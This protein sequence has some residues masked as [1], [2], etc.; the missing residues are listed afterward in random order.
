[1]GAHFESV[2]DKEQKA[3]EEKRR[4]EE[5][6]LKQDP[7]YHKIQNDPEVKEAL[8]DPKVQLVLQ[9]LQ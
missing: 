2:A 7:I 5:E 8:A 6:L 9:Q 1:M 3:A 4:K